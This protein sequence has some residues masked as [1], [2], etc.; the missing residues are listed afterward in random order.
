MRHVLLLTAVYLLAA[1]TAGDPVARSPRWNKDA[2]AHCRMA[3][4]EPAA[5][6]QLVGAGGLVRHYDDL[7]CLLADRAAHPEL[8]A[9][10]VFVVAPGTTESWVRAEQVRFQ[11]GG[12]TPMGFGYL[13]ALEG[14]LS[15]DEVQ[16]RLRRPGHPRAGHE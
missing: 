8:A 2:C 9:A 1:C 16:F 6:A 15:F 11:D 12:R 7:G 5:A 14:E 10:A 13:P 3:V 4:S